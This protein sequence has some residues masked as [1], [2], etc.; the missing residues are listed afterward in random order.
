MG[1][2]MWVIREPGW[3]FCSESGTGQQQNL[4]K[5][6]PEFLFCKNYHSRQAFPDGIRHAA[7]GENVEFP[8]VLRLNLDVLLRPEFNR[9]SPAEDHKIKDPTIVRQIE[10]R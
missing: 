3:G 9:N 8:N 5:L 1:G 6:L 10:T 4:R 2:R 7:R